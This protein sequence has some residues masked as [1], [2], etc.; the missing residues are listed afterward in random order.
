MAKLVKNHKVFNC[1]VL[2]GYEPYFEKNVV[3]AIIDHEAKT[4]RPTHGYF[5]P[6]KHG[7]Y[8]QKYAKSIGYQFNAE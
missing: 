3:V 1:D 5:P 6:H 4:I 8:S 2:E 7:K